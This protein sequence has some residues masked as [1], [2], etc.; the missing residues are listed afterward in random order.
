M[1]KHS[2]NTNA[3]HEK[4]WQKM[5]QAQADLELAQREYEAAQQKFKEV[6]WDYYSQ[7]ERDAVAVQRQQQERQAA[8]ERVK[9]AQIEAKRAELRELGV[10]LTAS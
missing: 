5:L 2:A 6:R 3:E 10:T 9:Q 1:K 4:L 8:V 7:V